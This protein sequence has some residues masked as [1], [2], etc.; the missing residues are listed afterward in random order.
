MLL[1]GG[2]SV[3]FQSKDDNEVLGRLHQKRRS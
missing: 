2:Q 3:D 1:W